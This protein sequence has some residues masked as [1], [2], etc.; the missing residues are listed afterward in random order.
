METCDPADPSKTGWGTAGCNTSCQPV[1]AATPSCDSLTA[2]PTFGTSPVTTTLTCSGS[3]IPTGATYAIDCGNGTAGTM[4]GNKGTCTY[5]NN[6]TTGSLTFAPKCTINSTITSPACQTNVVANAV[7][8][9]G[10]CSSTLSGALSAPISAGACAIGSPIN[11]TAIGSPTISYTWL[12][13]GTVG[14]ANSPAC[15]ASYTPPITGSGLFDLSIKKYIESNDAQP[16]APVYLQTGSG[17]NYIIRVRN[18]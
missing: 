7:P 9:A 12:C 5:V 11:F 6:T 17:F 1:T 15:T 14:G 8:V 16:D 10:V 13:A 4:N 3:N 18:E 2:S